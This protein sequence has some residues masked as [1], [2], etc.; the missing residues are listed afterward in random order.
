[1]VHIDKL[2]L[3]CVWLT[4]MTCITPLNV[5]AQ[6]LIFTFEELSLENSLEN[7]ALLAEQ[8][9]VIRI[10]GFWH[11]LSFGE[12]I[13]TSQTGIKS[14]CLKNSANIH[15]QVVVKGDVASFVEG[16]AITVEGIFKID[17]IY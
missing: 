12:G 9:K 15:Q 1:M 17:P 8:G 5:S 11:P 13:L 10:R 6:P 3:L 4:W 14:C 2:F 7:K 16:R